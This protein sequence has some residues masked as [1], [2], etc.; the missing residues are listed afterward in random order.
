[1]LAFAGAVLGTS[2]LD[3]QWLT[4]KA[5]ASGAGTTH[6]VEIRDFLFVP[7][8]LE[9]RAGDQITWINRDIAPHTATAID[10]SWDSGELGRA[11]E[12]QTTVEPDMET[13]Y[14]CRF[15]PMMKATLKIL[16][17]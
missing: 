12:W 8:R 10:A 5:S 14:F 4:G 2:A 9:V 16:P 6:V 15:H 11:E 13:E 7:D 17:S 3:G 1:M